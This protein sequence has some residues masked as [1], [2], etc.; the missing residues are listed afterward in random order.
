MAH[1][2]AHS[3][4]PSYRSH[5]SDHEIILPP[6]SAVVHLP[7]PPVAEEPEITDQDTDNDAIV[8]ATPSPPQTSV[9]G[10]ISIKK[11]NFFKTFGQPLPHGEFCEK[12]F[13]EKASK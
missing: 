5:I 9:P 10:E 4:P 11:S 1:A 12:T 2:I 8:V 13:S 7:K 6:G 3:R